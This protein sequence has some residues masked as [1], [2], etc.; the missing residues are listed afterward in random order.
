MCGRFAFWNDKN[1]IVQHY[2]LNDAPAFY[3]GYNVVPSYDIAVIRKGNDGGRELANCHWGL[4]PHWAKDTKLQPANARADGVSKKPFF[5]DAF[6]HRRC[7]IPANGYYEWSE[8]NGRKQPWFIRLKDS[9]LL[10]F[11]GIWSRRESPDNIIES[12]ALITTEPNPYLAKIH[13]RMPVIIPPDRYDEWLDT[14]GESMLLPYTGTMEA[15]PVSTAVNSPK[16]QGPE[17]IRP[18]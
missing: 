7:L 3:T 15:W 11:A 16:N 6:R 14:G 10:S 12:C 18:I 1:T 8:A 13:D 17:L 9:E 5:R 4:I 2:Q